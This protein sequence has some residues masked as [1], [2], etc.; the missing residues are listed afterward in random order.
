MGKLRR[1]ITLAVLSLLVFASA[2]LPA[3][4]RAVTPVSEVASGTSGSDLAS[5][6]IPTAAVDHDARL[7]LYITSGRTDGT[8]AHATSV[9]GL[10]GS[11]QEVKSIAV[12]SGN[13]Y[14]S[15]YTA[16]VVAGS[17]TIDVVFPAVQQ[18]FSWRLLAT[19]DESDTIVQSVAAYSSS[20]TPTATLRWLHPNRYT[21][22]Q[23]YTYNPWRC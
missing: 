19:A 14:S 22:H 5:Y 16:P 9:S 1:F 2:A 8:A 12:N 23:H 18:N 6:T 17:G 4:V 21:V 13:L 3:S 10:G 20:T 7:V 11:W 15:V